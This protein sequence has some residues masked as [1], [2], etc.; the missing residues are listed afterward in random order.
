M[1]DVDT[2]EFGDPVHHFEHS[3]NNFLQDIC[4]FAD[5]LICDFIRKGQNALQAIEKARRH[6]VIFI[7]FFQELSGQALCLLLTCMQRGRTSNVTLAT[8][9]TAFATGF[10]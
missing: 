8:P 1:S 6:L 4:L 9:K 5:D 7:L 10:N 3:R 2:R